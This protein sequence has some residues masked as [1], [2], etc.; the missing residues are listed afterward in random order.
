MNC[1]ILKKQLLPLTFLLSMLSFI[2]VHAQVGIN[3]TSPGDGSMLDIESSEKGVFIPKVDI[4]DLSTINPISG[5]GAT[6]ADLQAAEGLMVY[7]TNTTS[8]PGFFFWTGTRWQALGGGIAADPPIDSVS[9]TS[10]VQISAATWTDVAGMSL[11]FTARKTDALITFSASGFSFTGSMSFVQLRVRNITNITTIGGTSTHMQ[12]YDDITGSITAW[13]A[14]F[15][16]LLSG[17]TIG[18]TYTLQIQGQVS[19]ILGSPDAG[20]FPVTN[21][22]DHHMTLSV[23]Q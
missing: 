8:G 11:T 16:K 7:N 19:G 13:S 2:A 14:S 21:P 6:V 15:S 1:Q 12:S 18:N 5:V 3:T 9:L 20:I 10:D 22:D 4:V 17:L 23:I